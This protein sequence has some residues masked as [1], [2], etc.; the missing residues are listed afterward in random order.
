[1][2]NKYKKNKLQINFDV[3]YKIYK[4]IIDIGM[5]NINLYIYIYNYLYLE[6]FYR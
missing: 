2:Y 3:Y 5:Y 1:M 4:L 6:V